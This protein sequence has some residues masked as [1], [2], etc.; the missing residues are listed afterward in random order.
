M[1][2]FINLNKGKG[3]SSHDA[4][5]AV[6]RLLHVKAGHAGTLDP[7]AVGVLP[8]CLGKATR[9]AEYISVYPKAYRGDVI[10]GITTDSYDSDGTVI[11]KRS[12]Y[13]I[14]EQD[15]LDMLPGFTG[16]ILQVP[17]MVSALKHQGKPLY[18]LAR[19]GKE[20]E[21][22]ARPV[23]IYAIK[24]LNGNFQ[25]DNPRITLEI[26]CSKGTYIRS[27]AYD[28]GQALGVGAHL[29][30]L[31][32]LRVGPFEL[33]QSITLEELAKRAE[34][35]DHSFLL[36]LQYGVSYL[37]KVT[38][39]DKDFIKVLHG[40]EIYWAGDQ[41][42]YEICRVEDKEGRLLAIGSLRHEEE[43]AR[44]RMKKVLVGE[45]CAE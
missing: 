11:E 3:I 8:I 20:I 43:G 17:P 30:S 44:L 35:E 9:L 15:I 40:N 4:V 12:A 24:Y 21:R 45:E 34:A 16:D 2:G 41:R 23:S 32:R 7:G 6:R 27:L 10:L 26:S 19:E 5:A 18:Q 36:P 25:I 22:E 42:N 1:D 14:K 31:C 13:G 29:D 28:I 39:A 37:P 38:I 33:S